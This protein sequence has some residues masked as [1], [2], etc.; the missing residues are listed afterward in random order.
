[1]SELPV[2]SLGSAWLGIAAVIGI[3]CLVLGSP[4]LILEVSEQ[5]S[6]WNNRKLIKRYF[7]ER[8]VPSAAWVEE[9]KSRQH[10]L[11][12]D[13]EIKAFCVEKFG[14]D[15]V[16]IYREAPPWEHSWGAQGRDFMLC[17]SIPEWNLYYYS[18]NGK[19]TA[20]WTD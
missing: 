5:V 1:M 11:P 3:I 16:G 13:D 20:L 6:H 2:K 17:S 19:T 9:F 8:M 4:F 7:E 18:W 10:R 14:R 15:E 12:T